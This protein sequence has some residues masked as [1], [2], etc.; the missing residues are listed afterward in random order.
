MHLSFGGGNGGFL[1]LGIPDLEKIPT[2]KTYIIN[3]KQIDCI[4]II[5]PNIYFSII[6]LLIVKE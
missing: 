3:K 2:K 5:N 4:K 6:Y 1:H